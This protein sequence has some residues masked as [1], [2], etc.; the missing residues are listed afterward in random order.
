MP[1]RILSIDGGGLRGVVP[2]QI[3]K[4]IKRRTGREIVDSFD[5]IA[6]T[7][8]GGILAMAMNLKDPTNPAKPKY[9]LDEIEAIYSNHGK[10][11][12]P[13][14]KWFISKLYGK[15]RNMIRPRFSAKGLDS[16]LETYFGDTKLNDLLI[17][18]FITSYDVRLYRP[19][20][21]SVV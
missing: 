11:I 19:D 7:S 21:K 9:T 5:L 16:V 4:E 2:L 1:F 10:T 8:T 15:S 12:F 17:P 18:V 20:R 3:L 14:R 13:P 6:G